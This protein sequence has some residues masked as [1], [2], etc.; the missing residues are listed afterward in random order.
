MNPSRGAGQLRRPSAAEDFGDRAEAM[1]W[2][3]AEREDLARAVTAAP[4]AGLEDRAWRVILLQWPQAVRR[5]R[6]NWVAAAYTGLM[7]PT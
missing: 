6:D 5:S 1:G 2:P 7:R 4:A 3:A